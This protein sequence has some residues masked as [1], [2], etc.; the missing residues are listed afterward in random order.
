MRISVNIRFYTLTANRCMASLM[1][2][3]LVVTSLFNSSN[4]LDMSDVH[5]F[6]IQIL[7]AYIFGK[8]YLPGQNKCDC[9]KCTSSFILNANFY[10]AYIF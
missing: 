9:R 4:Y 2:G 3:Y 5:M 8:D 6:A 10:K 7:L 1:L